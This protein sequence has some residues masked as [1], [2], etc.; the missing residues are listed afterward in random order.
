M[1]RRNLATFSIALVGGAAGYLLAH[2]FLASPHPV[3]NLIAGPDT[4]RPDVRSTEDALQAL[5]QRIDDE[6]RKRRELEQRLQSLPA[7]INS[8]SVEVETSAIDA[9]DPDQELSVDS[10]LAAAGFTTAQI[11]AIRRREGE[12]SMRWIELDD[13]AR[14]EGWHDTAR[15]YEEAAQ[16]NASRYSLLNELGEQAYDRY[17]FTMGRPN[18]VAINSVFRTSPAEQSGLRPGDIIQTYAGERVFSVEQLNALRSGGTKG[19]PVIVE[20]FREGQLMQVTIPRGPMGLQPRM[21]VVDP[22]APSTEV[23]SM[24]R[25]N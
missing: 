15:Y 17:L 25:P 1:N 5:S 23:R 3:G 13:T 22:D 24:Y 21:S 4:S 9:P 20:I 18:R 12:E 6:A 10:R 11:D 2:Y 19:A 7:A 8:G 14:R 16:L